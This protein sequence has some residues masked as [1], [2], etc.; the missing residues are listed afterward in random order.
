MS[1]KSDMMYRAPFND[2]KQHFYPVRISSEVA[3]VQTSSLS[4]EPLIFKK[5]K[6]FFFLS[7]SPAV[8]GT[9]LAKKF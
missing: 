7:I 2:F 8:I 6:S 3:C 1:M 9:F 5:K 4:E